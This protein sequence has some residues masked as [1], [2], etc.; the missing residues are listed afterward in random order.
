MPYLPQVFL[1]GANPEKAGNNQRGGAREPPAEDAAARLA[2]RDA[3]EAWD[4][5]TAA[6]R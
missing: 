3:R 4:D 1:H 2:E 5:R 6:Q